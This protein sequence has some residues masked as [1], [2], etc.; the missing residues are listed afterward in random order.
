M[1]V[2]FT[3]CYQQFYLISFQVLDNG[4]VEAFRTSSLKIAQKKE[5]RKCARKFIRYCDEDSNK[6]ITEQEWI[7]CLGVKS[8]FSI[9]F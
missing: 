1:F 5:T 3:L 2:L 9:S 6:V 8:T 7:D 4:E